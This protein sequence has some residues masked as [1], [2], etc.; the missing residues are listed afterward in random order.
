MIS[1][2][3]K[4]YKHIQSEI[5]VFLSVFLFTLIVPITS[6]IFFSTQ[7]VSARDAEP[8]DPQKAGLIVRL[9]PDDP[10]ATLKIVRD[11]RLDG[12]ENTYELSRHEDHFE[13]TNIDI[14]GWCETGGS[15]V[16]TREFAKFTLTVTTSRGDEITKNID[17]TNNCGGVDETTVDVTDEIENKIK[18]TFVLSYLDPEN[19]L[20]KTPF[21]KTDSEAELV[22]VSITPEG[23]GDQIIF[24]PTGTTSNA[25]E[26]MKRVDRGRYTYELLYNSRIDC[27]GRTNIVFLE[28]GN[29]NLTTNKRVVRTVGPADFS[30]EACGDGLDLGLG[31]PEP[32]GPKICEENFRFPGSFIVCI[33]LQMV[34]KSVEKMVDAIADMLS[35]N[36]AE[37]NDD[38]LKAAWSYFRNIASVLLVVIGLVMIIGQAV[39]KE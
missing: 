16:F 31:E 34:D 3:T 9:E 15:T 18:L 7:N 12:V 22:R 10:D 8:D 29:L 32:D 30:V 20:Q 39:S 28:T 13:V 5:L 11:D 17:L 24:T 1:F 19:N 33:V 35:V 38:G 2:K 37:I 6:V 25:R 23:G 27:R 4:P 14:K 21:P 36:R 26:Y